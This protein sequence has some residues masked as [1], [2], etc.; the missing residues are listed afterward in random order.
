MTTMRVCARNKYL[1]AR[2]KTFFLENSMVL[3]NEKTFLS[4]EKNLL[5]NKGTVLLL[6]HKKDSL[7]KAN[8]RIVPLIDKSCNSSF[9]S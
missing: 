1:L 8:K 4:S 6:V 7:T 2:N 5:S 9:A 3:A